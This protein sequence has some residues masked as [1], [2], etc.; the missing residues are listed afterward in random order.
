MINSLRKETSLMKLKPN[1]SLKKTG[2]KLVKGFHIVNLHT[3]RN[4]LL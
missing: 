2:E 4:H 1:Y 3:F